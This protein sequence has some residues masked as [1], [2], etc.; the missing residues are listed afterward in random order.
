MHGL[1]QFGSMSNEE[2]QKIA[3]AMFKFCNNF[4]ETFGLKMFL[5]GGTFLGALREK[6][7]IDHDDD[8]DFNYYL[9]ESNGDEAQKKCSEIC[10]YY[11]SKGKL[12]H[13]LQR[14]HYQIWFENQIHFTDVW[15]AWSEGGMFKSGGPVGRVYSGLT[16]DDV[17]PLSKIEFRG[18][19]FNA[20][21][22]PEKFAVWMWGDTWG[23]VEK[24]DVGYWPKGNK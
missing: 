12:R 23:T 18:M 22:L 20:P 2:K 8:I 7:F 1:K 17:F 21:K 14:C 10:A 11:K 9:G 6:D 16:H 19:E 3:E 13:W 5:C 24:R 4:E 15:P